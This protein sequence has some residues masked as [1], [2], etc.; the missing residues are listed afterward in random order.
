MRDGIN[1]C[2]TVKCPS[3]FI[4]HVKRHGRQ[5]FGPSFEYMYVP[6]PTYAL[7]LSPTE[8]LEQTVNYTSYRPSITIQS[9]IEID[10][11]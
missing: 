3:C 7:R 9:L 11:V 6:Q 5:T 8:I 1:I 2:L 4:S 10:K